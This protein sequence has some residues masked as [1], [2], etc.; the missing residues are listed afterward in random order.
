[1]HTALLREDVLVWAVTGAVALLIASAT[2][3]SASLVD[4]D[5]DDW[6]WTDL[7]GPNFSWSF[8][9]LVI[10][11]IAGAVLTFGPV[12]ALRAAF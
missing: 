8:R 7:S 10:S 11:V 12:L 3:A 5:V 9:W 2:F 6:H 1:M 4:E